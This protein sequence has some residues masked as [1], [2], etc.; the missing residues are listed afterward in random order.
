M[1]ACPPLV[2]NTHTGPS[3]EIAGGKQS[4]LIHVFQLKYSPQSPHVWHM[5]VGNLLYLHVIRHMAS[6][7]WKVYMEDESCL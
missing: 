2:G 1:D 7:S 5:Y 4:V 3:R 6:Y